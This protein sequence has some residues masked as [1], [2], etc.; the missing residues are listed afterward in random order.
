[1]NV[2]ISQGQ[3]FL[4]KD[5]TLADFIF[6]T[7]S[8]MC[9]TQSGHRF[10]G[11]SFANGPLLPEAETVKNIQLKPPAF[12]GFW[13]QSWMT[14]QF[15][16]VVKSE[17]PAAV[18]CI[19]GSSIK[20]NIPQCV[21]IT[22]NNN[23]LVKKTDLTVYLVAFSGYLRQLLVEKGYQPDRIT[24]IRPVAS[25]LFVPPDW[26]TREAIKRKYAQQAE[27][28]FLQAG[29][30][31]ADRVV[32]VLKAF[33]IFKKWQKSTA[34]LLISVT[35][36]AATEGWMKLLP[37]YKFR[38]HV[39]V[40]QSISNEENA[41]I[42]A[43]AMCVLYFPDLD[44]TGI[45]LLGCIQAHVPVITYNNGAI[46]ETIEDAA[47]Y[48][49]ADD[50]EEIAEKMKKIYRD[51][52]LRNQLMQTLVKRAET[53]SDYNPAKRLWEAVEHMLAESSSRHLPPR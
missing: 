50:V 33:S 10:T 19:D 48:C 26:D 17:Q 20:T 3:D 4:S 32:N 2:I 29:N 38:E 47:L 31:S 18:I 8:Q 53:L 28:F 43:S 42:T 22:S 23:T 35:G 1:M 12:A 21:F 40:Q 39:V 25:N 24:V 52:K 16:A 41:L 27:Y 45:D 11:L 46:Q 44:A 37:S 5:K 6:N 51:E 36:Y 15:A 49:N 13:K 14:R 9:V 30:M 7:I 34:R